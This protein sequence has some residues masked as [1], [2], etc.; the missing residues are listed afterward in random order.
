MPATAALYAGMHLLQGEIIRRRAR[1][2]AQQLAAFSLHM[3]PLSDMPKLL[4][5]CPNMETLRLL[6]C[7]NYLRN[8]QIDPLTAMVY[9]TAPNLRAYGLAQSFM[10]CP[11]CGRRTSV[12][13]G[14]ARRCEHCGMGI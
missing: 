11:H 3:F 10:T 8:I 5:D 4:P 14:A 2:V 13:E 6:L 9:L 7:G 1:G 12:V